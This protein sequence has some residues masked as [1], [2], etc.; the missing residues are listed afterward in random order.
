MIEN[1][2]VQTYTMF[3]ANYI[4]VELK[5]IVFNLKKK[6][7]ERE[8]RLLCLYTGAFTLQLQDAQRKEIMSA[9]FEPRSSGVGPDSRLALQKRDQSIVFEPIDPRKM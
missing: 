8:N 9:K 3:Y 1:G 7:L 4:S 2:K 6:L 5:K